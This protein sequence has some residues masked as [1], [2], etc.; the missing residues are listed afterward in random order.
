V[1]LTRLRAALTAGSIEWEG[2][3]LERLVSRNIARA[4][5][6]RILRSGECIEDYPADFPFP[7]G[8]FLGWHDD[9][10]LH[11]VAA[12]EEATPRIFIITAYEPDTEHF[13]DDFRTRRRK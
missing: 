7:S 12:L 11:V 6:L 3:V 5:V 4:T 13:E 9:K 8:L 2:H 10:P 1:N